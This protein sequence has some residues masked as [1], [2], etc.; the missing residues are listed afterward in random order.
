[1]HALMHHVCAL[2]HAMPGTL[3]MNSEDLEDLVK[4]LLHLGEILVDDRKISF[5]FDDDSTLFC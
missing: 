3:R 4:I 2:P 5:K 1:M